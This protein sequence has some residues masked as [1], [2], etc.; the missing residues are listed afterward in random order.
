MSWL[1]DSVPE[2]NSTPNVHYIDDKQCPECGSY[3][4]ELIDGKYICWKCDYEWQEW[5]YDYEWQKSE[6]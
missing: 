4:I 6:E 2:R 1:Y 5:E 3:N